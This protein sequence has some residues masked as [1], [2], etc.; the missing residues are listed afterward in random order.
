MV[1][2]APLSWEKVK[3]FINCLDTLINEKKGECFRAIISPS[4]QGVQEKTITY[5]D[6]IN[7]HCVWIKSVWIQ[8]M[9]SESEI[10]QKMIHYYKI[11]NASK[12]LHLETKGEVTFYKVV[13]K[14][15]SVIDSI[16]LYWESTI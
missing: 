1:H 4:K 15:L 10:I 7:K 14:N 11:W 2:S 13:Q 12:I 6:K 5:V 3:T 8:Y 16:L 9:L